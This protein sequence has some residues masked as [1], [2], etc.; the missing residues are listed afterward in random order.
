MCQ[1]NSGRARVIQITIYL[2][3]LFTLS[4][5]HCLVHERWKPGQFA[6]GQL[7]CGKACEVMCLQRMKQRVIGEFGLDDHFTGL[8]GASG[9]SGHLHQL[10]E[11]LSG[12][13]KRCCTAHYPD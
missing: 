3:F 12:A 4:T 9:A 7:R 10:C 6:L 11:D 2:D 13:R 8:V 5:Q 1:R